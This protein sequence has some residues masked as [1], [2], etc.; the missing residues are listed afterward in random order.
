MGWGHFQRPR[1]GEYITFWLIPLHYVHKSDEVQQIA[2]FWT[3]FAPTGYG[4]YS[5]SQQ[6]QS[7]FEAYLSAPIILVMFLGYKL[8]YRTSFVRT[9]DIDL[10]TGR[11]E[12][13]LG[14]ILAEE[15]AE[16]SSWSWTRRAWKVLC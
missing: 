7:F 4:S 15:R 11:R 6:V 14:R 3:G 5:A 10:V 2:Q 12:L 16:K 13:E 1:A 8:I 9:R